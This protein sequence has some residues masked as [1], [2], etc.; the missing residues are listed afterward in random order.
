MATGVGTA[1]EAVVLATPGSTTLWTA[2]DLAALT[3]HAGNT[4]PPFVLDSNARVPG[5]DLW[6]M[7]P[8]EHADGSLPRFDGAA[9][10]MVLA[11]TVEP[12]PDSRH[13]VARIYLVT[14]TAGR[15]T[16][17]QPVFPD[18]FTPGDR[19]WSGSAVLDDS[20][21][22]LTVF[23]TAAGRRDATGPS[24]EQRLF[25]AHC[26]FSAAGGEFVLSD[27]SQPA[28][29][30]VADGIDYMVAN[31]TE[32]RGG[33]ILGFRDPGFFRD[34]ATGCAYLFFTGSCARSSSRWTGNIGVAEQAVGAADWQI[35]PPVFSAAGVNNE[36][37]RPHMR[38]R[39]GLYYLFWSTQAKVFAEGL[40]APTGLYGAVAPSPKGPFTL[41]NGTGL[42]AGTPPECPAQEYSWWVMDDLQVIGFADFPGIRDMAQI[43]D[44]AQRRAH[45]AGYPAPFFRIALEGA[46]AQVV[47]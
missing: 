45:F 16:L 12:D 35:Q 41:L 25:E 46:T 7:W 24:L 28:E 44:A 20:A 1:D 34:S 2:S 26:R 14:E 30:I 23:F 33:E 32:G 19:E 47:P 8:V 5:F 9:L 40:H 18:G 22:Q 36:L 4:I 37:E 39:D 17:H 11:A 6:D 10:W 3:R 29:T 42:V 21:S 13:M 31:Q 38:Q 27:W 15:W 43:V